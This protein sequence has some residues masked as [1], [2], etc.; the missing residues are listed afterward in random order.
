MSLK[1]EHVALGAFGPVLATRRAAR[2]VVSHLE[3]LFDEPVALELSFADVEAVTSPFLDEILKAVQSEMAR[4]ESS[5]VS[6]SEM[7][8]DAYE[9]LKMVL[10]RDHRA[11]TY[12]Q[13]D[14][15]ELVT[16]TPHLAE[17]YEA[18][19]GFGTFT[20]PDLAG[21][22]GLTVTAANQRLK[23]LSEA[24]AVG[25]RPDANAERGRRYLYF[26]MPAAIAA[27]EL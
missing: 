24:G 2:D 16:S 13:K 20:T 8:E 19:Q 25:R 4:H 26:V 14:H 6:A 9:T 23:T 21:T 15:Y 12:R 11:L 1:N 17:T 10:D 7:N 5:L 3:G 18:A 27:S 22:L